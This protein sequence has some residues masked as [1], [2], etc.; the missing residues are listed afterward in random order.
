[1]YELLAIQAMRHE[2][3]QFYESSHNDIIANRVLQLA[4]ERIRREEHL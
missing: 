2:Q 4:E 1:M 3:K